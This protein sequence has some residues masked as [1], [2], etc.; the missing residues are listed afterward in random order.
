MIAW[1]EEVGDLGRVERV[2]IA[3][4]AFGAVALEYL[5]RCVHR[6]PHRW[7]D[8]LD[9]SSVRS[10]A[11]ESR[12]VAPGDAPDDSVEGPERDLNLIQELLARLGLGKQLGEP[13]ERDLH[14]V[15]SSYR[16]ARRADRLDVRQVLL[17]KHPV[18]V[19]V[20]HVDKCETGRA[21][22]G[23]CRDSESHRA[24]PTV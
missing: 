12:L 15:S 16:R 19:S 18:D 4:Q 22:A 11:G 23:L 17:H 5:D 10:L 3:G 21:W 6:H 20:Q 14:E 2:L 13:K 1:H 7:G 9:N 8:H 24:D